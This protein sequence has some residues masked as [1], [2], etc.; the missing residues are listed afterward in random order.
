MMFKVMMYFKKEVN[1][2][3]VGDYVIINRNAYSAY[4]HPELD[5]LFYKVA[6]IIQ[7][8][9]FDNIIWYTLDITQKCS[10]HF[11]F[12]ERFLININSGI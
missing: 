3:K 8:E 2:L 7:I 11:K 5:N 12:N 9:T 6:R 10:F 4:Y 1:M